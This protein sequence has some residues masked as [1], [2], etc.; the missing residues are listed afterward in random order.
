MYGESMWFGR[1]RSAQRQRGVG[2]ITVITSSTFVLICLR[3]AASEVGRGAR[4]G[5]RV[6]LGIGLGLELKVRL[7]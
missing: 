1:G 2:A 6:G 3:W 4:G 7:G 5:V